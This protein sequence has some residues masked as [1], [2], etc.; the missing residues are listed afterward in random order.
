MTDDSQEFGKLVDALVGKSFERSLAVNSIKLRFGT[1]I[2]PKG[3]HYIW[4]DPP[5]ELHSADKLVTTSED[6]DEGNFNEWSLLFDPLNRDTLKSWETGE[7]GSVVFRTGN[8]YMI[9]LPFSGGI[10]DEDHWYSHWYASQPNNL[11]KRAR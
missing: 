10:R 2:D 11:S 4:I 8:G 3:T 7:N 1:K 9:V 5:W 6:Y